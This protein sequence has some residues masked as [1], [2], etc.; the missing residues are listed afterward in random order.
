MHGGV[1]VLR[2][3]PLRELHLDI[4]KHLFRAEVHGQHRAEADNGRIG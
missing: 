4:E 1:D 3:Q 2:R